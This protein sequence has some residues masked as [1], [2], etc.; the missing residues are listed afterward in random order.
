M[1]SKKDIE[2]A[3]AIEAAKVEAAKIEAENIHAEKIG[4]YVAWLSESASHL[5]IAE[6]ALTL[7]TALAAPWKG[8]LNG[9]GHYS[10]R[11]KRDGYGIAKDVTVIDEDG[12]VASVIDGRIFFDWPMVN[13]AG[14]VNVPLVVALHKGGCHTEAYNWGKS[15]A[16]EAKDGEPTF[17]AGL[18]TR[19]AAFPPAG[20]GGGS[21]E[22]VIWEAEIVGRLEKHCPDMKAHA[23]NKLAK[24]RAASFVAIL[25]AQIAAGM[26]C[27]ADLR[28]KGLARIET[29]I[30]KRVA[31][32]L[33]RALEGD[34]C[35]DLI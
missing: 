30:A 27:T 23:M 11:E 10:V 4:T 3:A 22:D 33:A 28:P 31:D 16:Y 2:A 18:N 25:D 24:N 8:G 20:R 32:A 13:A 1:T 29:G 14:L 9:T 15:T 12:A 7:H 34:D 19:I 35:S 26:K 6:N 21:P 17:V 5:A